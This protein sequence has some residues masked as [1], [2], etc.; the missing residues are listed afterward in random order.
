MIVEPVELTHPDQ[1]QAPAHLWQGQTTSSHLLSAE[2]RMSVQCMM[3][4][5]QIHS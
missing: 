1:A 3:I 4:V 2:T 5:E